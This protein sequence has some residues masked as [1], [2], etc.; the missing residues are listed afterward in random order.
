MK[1]FI[2][3]KLLP[4]GLFRTLV[5]TFLTIV[6]G[7]FI[8]Y[9]VMV[10]ISP[11]ESGLGIKLLLTEGF[12]DLPKVIRMATPIIFTGLSVAFAFR[13]GLFNI[14][15][16]GQF[17]V[18]SLAAIYVGVVWDMPYPFHWIVALL[19]GA[20]AGFIWGLIPGLLKS[21]RNVHEV[22][23]TIMLN[24]IAVFLA[25]YVI[26]LP[27]IFNSLRGETLPVQSSARSA[28]LGSID[29]AFILA[30]VTAVIVFIYLFKTKGG[31][32]LRAV[33]FSRSAAKYAGVNEKFNMS[34]SMAIAG[35]LSGLGGAFLFLGVIHVQM[36]P[37]DYLLPQ[38][39]DGISVAL[40][41]AS[42]PLGVI[43][44]GLFIGFLRV[45]GDQL[46]TAN[47]SLEL[48]DIIVSSII[49]FVA[50]ISLIKLTI[51][52][53]RDLSSIKKLFSKKD[54]EVE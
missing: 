30:I 32:E 43:F 20:I 36:E 5:A 41:G 48:V 19:A 12:K 24:Y 40:I 31:Y 28:A 25:K 54:K 50:F 34:L 21:F 47:F 37:I 18:G 29:V 52:K 26:K 27:A 46:Q 2:K 14:G 16:T 51:F 53:K 15:A 17:T 6:I 35:L 13:T 38:G 10:L 7:L 8:S 39:F 11:S 1:T 23:A 42:H 45:G 49:Y 33:G 9:L 4:N 22:V 3:E 44:S